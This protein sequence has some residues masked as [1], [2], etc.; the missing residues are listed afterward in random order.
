MIYYNMF[1][2]IENP[3]VN[4]LYFSESGWNCK[5]KIDHKTYLLYFSVRIVTDAKI[6]N[7][8]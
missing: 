4:H 2:L 5:S 7:T 1:L 6:K 3:M 8:I